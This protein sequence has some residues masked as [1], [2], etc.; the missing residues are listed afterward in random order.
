MDQWRH[1]SIYHGEDLEMK[2]SKYLHSKMCCKGK[3]YL[4]TRTEEQIEEWIVEWY[5]SEFNE[6]GCDG[7]VAK[8]RM[9]PTWLAKWNR[10]DEME[11]DYDPNHG[12][13]CRNGCEKCEQ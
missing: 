3:Y 6:V 9:P 4:E 11:S 8:S 2:L 1:Y 13:C 12:T 10:D 5:R 7:S